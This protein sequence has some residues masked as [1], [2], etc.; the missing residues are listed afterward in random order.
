LRLTDEDRRSVAI[1][2]NQSFE[3]QNVACDESYEGQDEQRICFKIIREG[4]ERAE[5][6]SKKAQFR[7]K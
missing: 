2:K 5:G 7:G 4:D 3:Q 6:D 1:E